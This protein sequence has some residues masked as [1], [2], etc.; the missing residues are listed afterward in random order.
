M[1]QIF[2]LL[3]LCAGMF[4][5]AL[6]QSPCSFDAQVTTTAPS[7]PGGGNGSIA[8]NVSG[9]NGPFTFEW[10]GPNGSLGTGGAN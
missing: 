4:T 10:H 3:L 2:T 5:N 8:V 7:C 1:K 9:A 6:P